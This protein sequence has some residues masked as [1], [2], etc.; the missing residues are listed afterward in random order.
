AAV[1]L[2]GAVL[3]W[4]LARPNCAG[5]GRGS[6]GLLEQGQPLSIAPIKVLHF[7]RSPDGAAEPRGGIGEES[8]TT[9]FDDAVT[10]TVELSRPAH[11]YL[12]ALNANGKEQ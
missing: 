2:P 10:I 8:F 9:C 7:A 5:T 4:W 11:L 1:V 3:A 12:I 6:G